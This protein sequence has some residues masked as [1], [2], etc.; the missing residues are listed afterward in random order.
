MRAVRPRASWLLVAV[1]GVLASFPAPSAHACSPSIMGLISDRRVM[2]YDGQSGV[3][4]NV[5]ITVTYDYTGKIADDLKLQSIDGVLVPSST[6]QEFGFVLTPLAPLQ[7]NTQ[8]QVLSEWA[9]LPCVQGTADPA[10]VPF[11]TCG[12]TK[13]GGVVDSGSP[14]DGGALPASFVIATFTTGSG[15][16]G[17]PPVL[18][19]DLS[20]TTTTESCSGGG[21]CVEYTGVAIILSWNAASDDA[22]VA[23]YEAKNR[24]SGG[25][26]WTFSPSARGLVFC[27]GYGPGLGFQDFVGTPGMY[28]VVAVDLAGNRSLPISV[29]V[30]VD[31]GSGGGCSC[32]L[33]SRRGGAATAILLVAFCL[34]L[35]KSV[36]RLR[37]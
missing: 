26:D 34:L 13:D 29:P 11:P 27:A 15:V 3:P 21:C 31:C 4:T 23:Y 28:Q 22:G 5:Q 30:S 24:D 19:G 37:S 17:V 35:A 9:V 6:S 7:P 20:Y 10:P 14:A 1:L 8:Y 36:L 2:P 16:D 33:A 25:T 18:S 12:H 32:Q